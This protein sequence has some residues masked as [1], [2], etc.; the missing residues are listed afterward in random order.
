M[1]HDVAAVFFKD[2]DKP[3]FDIAVILVFRPPI[4]ATQTSTLPTD[5]CHV[6]LLQAIP[7]QVH[8]SGSG[9]S[10]CPSAP[11]GT[12]TLTRLDFYQLK[13][14]KPRITLTLPTDHCHVTSLQAVPS[15]VHPLRLRP[16]AKSSPTAPIKGKSEL[17]GTCR[18]SIWVF[19]QAGVSS[20]TPSTTDG[21]TLLPPAKNSNANGKDHSSA[22][23]LVR[24]RLVLPLPIVD[25]TSISLETK[26]EHPPT[27]RPLPP[28]PAR[29]SGSA[30]SV[31]YRKRTTW[32]SL[33][34]GLRYTSRGNGASY[35][36][37]K[38]SWSTRYCQAEMA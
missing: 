15:Q 10:R 13:A 17:R 8:P 25:P 18:P 7:S 3:T 35:P 12:Q 33:A 11:L 23:R 31:H 9:R 27:R 19:A 22:P 30:R 32:S 6:T 26:I 28:S 20:R 24:P 5:L 21:S 37:A 16:R 14:P 34:A 4:V 2:I 36:M 38:S 1:L 29:L